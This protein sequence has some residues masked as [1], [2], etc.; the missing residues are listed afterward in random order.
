MDLP[1]ESV[2][3][4]SA[5]PH[6][7][8][9]VTSFSRL[10][11]GVLLMLSSASG[12]LTALWV[13]EILSYPP[14]SEEML[15]TIGP[16][17]FCLGAFLLLLAVSS[18]MAFWGSLCALRATSYRVAMAGGALALFSVGPYFIGSAFGLVGLLL[19]RSSR[20]DPDW[21]QGPRNSGFGLPPSQSD[22]DA[23]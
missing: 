19:I 1:T 10:S 17:R 21:R 15:S 22:M 13:L 16:N 8:P 3:L 20:N 5:I 4:K 6:R 9:L 18:L 23:M 12:V 7:F 2:R 14:T 11:G